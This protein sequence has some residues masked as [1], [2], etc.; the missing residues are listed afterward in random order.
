VKDAF[1]KQGVFAATP[2]NSK[3]ASEQLT[4]EVKRWEA[5]NQ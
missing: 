5:L 1:L 4:A 3:I 2:T